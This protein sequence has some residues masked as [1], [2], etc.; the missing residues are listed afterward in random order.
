MPT[1]EKAII[2]ERN[3]FI[4]SSAVIVGIIALVV[5][6]SPMALVIGA[7][8]C[9]MA[10]LKPLYAL[11]AISLLVIIR[12]IN[13]ALS[14]TGGELTLFTWLLFFIAF[15][16]YFFSAFNKGS[17]IFIAILAFSLTA[18]AL[19]AAVGE[20]VE[21][22]FFKIIAFYLGSSAVFSAI[23]ALQDM[24]DVI[25]LK[26]WLFSV[27]AVVVVL[28]LPTLLIPDIAY[29]R[30][31]VG[32]Q[33]I[34]NHPQTLG[35]FLAPVTTY[36][37]A[38]YFF[39][40]EKIVSLSLVAIGVLLSLIFLTQ[41]RTSLV[42]LMLSLPIVFFFTFGGRASSGALQ[43]NS[44]LGQ[45][46]AL[47]FTFLLL[48]LLFIPSSM[49]VINDFVYKRESSSIDDALSSRSSGIVGQWEN[50]LSNPVAGSGF[51]VYPGSV[52]AKEVVYKFGLPISAAVEKGFIPT[53]ILEEVGIIGTLV[54]LYLLFSI[55]KPVLFHR[56][57][58]WIG[59]FFA[60]WLI[61]LGEA[62][63]FST[64][65]IGIFY[66]CLMAFAVLNGMIRSPSPQ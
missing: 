66:W 59:L 40:Q 36:L 35:A 10:L 27:M 34:L 45:K 24:R 3:T 37:I 6:A 22:S 55:A 21:I 63:F 31:A 39:S 9:V 1:L 13:P 17:F 64:G 57:P 60:C 20:W 15:A 43:L 12:F 65:G 4:I 32:F 52:P 26:L 25:R 62:V 50:F 23:F 41:A 5:I 54:F 58:A 53:A 46:L 8:M 18:A 11:Q 49:D 38:Y 44:R 16:R 19:S 29:N 7:G 33:G 14:G 2:N 48:A 28:S 42:A 30:N 56:K 47:I 51:G 61:N